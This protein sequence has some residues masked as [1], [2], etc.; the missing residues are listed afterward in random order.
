MEGRDRAHPTMSF[1]RRL[2]QE[3]SPVSGPPSI[4]CTENVNLSRAEVEAKGG[5]G[6]LRSEV[7]GGCDPPEWKLRN[8]PKSSAEYQVL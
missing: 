4:A 7:V 3:A 8:K 1:S 5:V 6:V 2:L